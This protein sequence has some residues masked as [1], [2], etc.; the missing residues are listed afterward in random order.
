MKKFWLFIFSSLIATGIAYYSKK[1]PSSLANKPGWNTFEKKSAN[2]ISAHPSTGKELEKAR[3][4]TPK[5][6]IAQEKNESFGKTVLPKDRAYQIRENRLLIGDIDRT[7]YQNE[8]TDLV[9]LNKINPDWKNILGNDLLRFQEE[10]TKVMIKEEFPVIKVQ[11]GKGIYLEQ[12]V[13]TYVFKNGNYSSFHALVDSDTG[14]VTETWDR[15]VHEKV[16]QKR[17]EIA[18]PEINT[19]GII[20]R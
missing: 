12:V 13:V 3:I 11:N 16:K 2:H 9:M 19:S 8:N 1:A 15:T 17:A 18:L 20:T 7:D 14:F 4:P 5:R 6:S 10:E